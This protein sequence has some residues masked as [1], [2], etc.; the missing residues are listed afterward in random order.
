MNRVLLDLLLTAL[1][2]MAAALV[3]AVLGVSG[4]GVLYLAGLIP[5]VG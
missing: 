5:T 1:G 2:G 3:L 4:L